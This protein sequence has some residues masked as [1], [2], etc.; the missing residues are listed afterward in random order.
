MH[1]SVCDCYELPRELPHRFPN[2]FIVGS[3]T[4]VTRVPGSDYQNIDDVLKREPLKIFPS[5]VFEAISGSYY[6]LTNWWLG[7]GLVNH[8]PLAPAAL[9]AALP[10]IIVALPLN[11]HFPS[12]HRF[13]YHLSHIFPKYTSPVSTTRTAVPGRNWSSVVIK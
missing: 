12:L 10:T 13:V 8:P 9:S 1:P 2:N 6:I 5:H 3:D 11:L 4:T 7:L